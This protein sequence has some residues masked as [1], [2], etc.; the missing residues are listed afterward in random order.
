M[1]ISRIQ[2]VASTIG[3]VLT[4]GIVVVPAARAAL[5]RVPVDVST[6]Q[7]AIQQAANGD[8]IE[9]AAGTYP[10][11]AGGF[12]ISSQPK[13]FTIR[14]ASGAT[15]VLDGGNTRDVLRLINSSLGAGRPVTFERLTFANGR[16]TS[17]GIAGGVTLQRAQATFVQCV[18]QNNRGDQPSTGGGG[19]R[20]ALGSTALFTDCQWTG[21]SAKNNGG[22]LAITDQSEA[23][24]HASQFNGNRTN[25]PGHSPIA[26]AG[27]IFVGDATLR[28]S[29]TRFVG[30][31]A[32]YVGGGLYAIG[33]WTN[34]VSTPRSDVVVSN[35]TFVDNVAARDPSVAFSGPPEGGAFHAE[36]QTRARIYN[37]RF[38]TN[39]A[40]IGGGVNLYRAIVEVYGSVF[41][42]NQASSF[43]G[44][45]S[46]T[47]NDVNDPSTNFGAINRRP[48]QLTVRDTLIRGRFGAVGTVAPIAGGLYAAG[49]GL[50][51]YG[52]NGV[53]QM[54]TATDNR[55][56]VTLQ[57]V[58]FSDC[59][60]V[61][62]AAVPGSGQG[63][64]LYTDLAAL[65]M[66]DSLVIDSDAPIA[67]GGVMLINQSAA[68]INRITIARNSAGSFGAGIFLQ[69]SNLVFDN[70][71]IVHNEIS[72]GVSEPLG[73]SLG[74]AIYASPDGG[75]LSA[76]GSVSNSIISSNVGLPIYDDDRT[77]GPINDVRYN[78]NQIWSTTFGASVYNNPLTGTKTVA[79]LNTL[80]VNRANGTSTVKS[81]V[82][83][84]ALASA[85][86]V[87]AI[88]AVP[89]VILPVNAA[90][91]P[92]PPTTSYLGY[93][94]SGGGATL[95]G[96][97]VSGNAGLSPAT[98]TGTH[99]LAV[100][101]AQF[102]V[103]VGL[104]AAPAAS[105]SA[106]PNPINPG[107]ISTLSWA[108][109]GG[110]FLDGAID[111]GVAIP[112]AAAGSI[113]VT[114][115]VSTTY[116]FFDVTQE[117][118]DVAAVT[119]VSGAPPP[120][121]VPTVTDPSSGQVIGVEGVTFA[122]TAVNGAT[123]YDLRILEAATQAA[124]FTG[125]LSGGGSTTTLI[126]V[127][128]N[129][130]YTFQ[131]RACA[132][133]ISDANCGGFASRNFGVNLIA[134]S[135]A[136]TVTFPGP[137]ASFTSSRQTLKWTAV[138]GNPLLPDLFYEVR[139]VN[140]STGQT[141]LQ[142]RTRHPAVQ[143]DV[144]LRSALYRMQVRACQAGCGPFSAAVD[145]AV[146]LGAVPTSAPSITSAVV[147]GGNSLTASWTAVAGAEWYQLQV[148]Q[149]RPAGPG[150]GALTVAARQVS[151]A[152]GATLPVPAGQA[153][154]I[155]AACNGDGC[156]PYSS[157]AGITPT[158]P[159]PAAPQIG[160]PLDG[161]VV[162]G[163]STLF[164]WSRIP[165]DTGNTVYRLYVQDVSRQRAA[166]DVYTSQ[167][168]YGALLNA[169]GGKYAALVIA[170][171]GP[172]QVAGPP[173]TFTVR[174]S[175]AVAPTLMAP[176]LGSVMPAGNV[177]LGWTPVPGATLY[178]YLVSVQGAAAA[179][180]RGVTQGIFV[181]VPLAAVNGQATVYSGIVRTCPAGQTCSGASDAGWGPWSSDAGSGVIS[182][183]VTP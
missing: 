63:G 155:V 35:C 18:F 66:Q 85:P 58:V 119:V 84:S 106:S 94:W 130:S 151:G 98:G 36:D 95:D 170:D 182:F 141:E 15:V 90:G 31:Q 52:L 158:G 123:G 135:A 146:A 68:T 157:A 104:A 145:F 43:G 37:S 25:L 148:V 142:L 156:G 5:L 139:L 83:N 179:S 111:Q 17:E 109:P 30:N 178:E 133:A 34:P 124:I 23:Y 134:P 27:G 143:T 105:L 13:A 127:P 51:Q 46:A 20:V 1:P 137:G 71:R 32:G 101:G 80:V 76:T 39:R 183:T 162:N 14:A 128:N 12:T 96:N 67:G 21:N 177:L 110:T 65:T 89:P 103:P 53:Q 113:G 114:P 165:G 60:V 7:A 120:L 181:Q 56:A 118:G 175:S 24:V 16:S 122:W 153:S 61:V 88:L 140:R 28:V 115:P 11:P 64:A 42:G 81:Q 92:A 82:D 167:N 159:N 41:E 99:V 108:T 72:P 78:G 26:M 59:D 93:A 152:T 144:L 161:S 149:P 69:G 73:G 75:S 100:G 173:I 86:L 102:S 29:N 172:G 136:P 40:T 49:D 38:T 180:G 48:A 147:S 2:R 62:S 168:F 138:T 87:G 132:G 57:N 33:T 107:S 125:S 45:F 4:L 176:T 131:V 54:G 154:V 163:P 8:V 171:P 116:R 150:G 129:G 55:A 126:G 44:A 22:G 164:A 121:G 19:T 117:G 77:N 169:E 6:L 50:R 3:L 174:G 79:Q 74:A 160:S 10:S 47:S 97:A 9:L 70:G 112:S 91:D 166:L